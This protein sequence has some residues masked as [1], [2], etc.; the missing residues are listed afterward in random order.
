M[1]LTKG[2]RYLGAELCPDVG[3][4]ELVEL[5]AEVSEG[6]PSTFRVSGEGGGTGIEFQSTAF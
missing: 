2:R 4:G 1:H 6:E 3:G 5:V